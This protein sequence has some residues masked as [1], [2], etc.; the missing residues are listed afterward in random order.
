VKRWKESENIEDK[1]SR[2]HC[3]CEEIEKILFEQR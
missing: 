2:P 3:L 1:S